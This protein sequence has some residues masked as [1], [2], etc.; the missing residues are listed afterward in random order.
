[1]LSF[2]CNT[3]VSTSLSIE[4]ILI[5]LSIVGNGILKLLRLP[6][7]TNCCVPPLES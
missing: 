1:M 3:N 7:E 2:R 5:W 4:A 6:K